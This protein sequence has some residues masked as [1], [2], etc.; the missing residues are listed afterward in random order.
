MYTFS[1]MTPPYVIC[2]MYIKKISGFNT[3][4]CINVIT[5]MFILY[6]HPSPIYEKVFIG[7]L[8][9][10]GVHHRIL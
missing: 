5:G 9:F 10:S 4:N 2:G 6:T 3:A 8:A 7:F 1:P